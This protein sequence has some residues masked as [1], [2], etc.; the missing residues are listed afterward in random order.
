MGA[1]AEGDSCF[2]LEPAWRFGPDPGR[3]AQIPSP[4][5]QRLADPAISPTGLC[6]GSNHLSRAES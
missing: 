2:A 5:L 4:L 1:L 6:A 3:G